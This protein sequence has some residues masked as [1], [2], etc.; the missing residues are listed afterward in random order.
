MTSNRMNMRIF[1]L[2]PLAL[3]ALAGCSGS[4]SDSGSGGIAAKLIWS[5]AKATAKTLYLAPAGVATVRFIVSGSGMTTMK[6]DFAASAGV[7]TM[8][9]VLAGT[10]RTLTAQGLDGSG[11]AIYQG[12]V[13]NVTV[14]TNQTTDVGAITMLPLT[15]PAAPSGLNATA[16]SASQINLTWTD[17]ATNETGFKVERKSGINGTYAQIGM[18]AANAV[19]YSDNGLSASTT[20]YY[21]V[22]STN[23]A[24]DS[25]AYSNESSTTTLAGGGGGG[26]L[27]TVQL[28]KTGQ[29][30]SYA[31]GDDGALQK[32]VAWPNPRF[33]DNANGTVTDNLTGLIW[34]KNANCFGFKTWADALTAANVLASGACGLTDGSTTGQ[35]RLPN[36]K[37]LQ[38]IVDRSKY[39][40][41]LQAGHPFTGVQ[42]NMYWSSSSDVGSIGFAWYVY[43]FD[44]YVGSYY[45]TSSYYV[46]PVRA[47]Q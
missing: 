14:Q 5:D 29:T 12:A 36:R 24:G 4:T 19:S 30:T 46:W 35:W 38:S 23:S 41:A 42:S 7:G 9:G 31:A 27:G 28:P 21:R 45:K 15:S 8:P 17:N 16:A 44:G 37:E 10:G 22:R 39:N 33:T 43:M 47:V 32:G 34:L 26:A 1:L 13:S 18:A 20:Y 25:T 2:L 40:P 11:A 6:Q 3:I